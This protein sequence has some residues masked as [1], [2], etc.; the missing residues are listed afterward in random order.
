M[1]EAMDWETKVARLDRG[2]ERLLAGL[3]PLTVERARRPEEV[4]ACQRLRYRTA[5]EMGWIGA[6]DFPDGR[7]RDEYDDA[8]IH[9]VCRERGEIVGCMRIVPPGP[10]RPLPVERDFDLRVEPAGGAVELGRVATTPE[11]RGAGALPF[12]AGLFAAGW[13]ECRA[14]GFET[15]VAAASPSLVSLYRAMGI[16]IRELGPP[17]L[18]WG[19]QRVPFVIDGVESDILLHGADGAERPA[20]APVTRRSLLAGGVAAAGGLV[21]LGL[22]GAAAGQAPGRL[23]GTATTDRTAIGFIGRVD[24]AGRTLS[25]LGRLTRVDGLSL[26]SLSTTPPGTIS[27]DPAAADIS[28]ARLT[29]VVNARIGAVSVLGSAITAVGAGTASIHVLPAGGARFE[30]PSSFR[31][32]RAV[33]TFALRFQNDLSLDSPDNGSAAL[34]CDLTQRTARAFTLDG[35]R[36]RIGAARLPWTLR[37]AGRGVRT[38][39]TTPRSQ[40]FVSGGLGVVDAEP[41]GG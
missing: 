18:H 2:A 22:P 35:R 30:D 27:T 10:H 1:E 21:V 13:L 25:G 9:L 4:D 36:L 33:A 8:A 19:D 24:Q 12:V 15:A 37:A 28:L 23:V 26:T 14:L 11:L 16:S 29:L 20:G 17:R 38:E 32:G 6:E 31:A 3:R 40:F 5:V 39:P 34:T 41:A 7:E